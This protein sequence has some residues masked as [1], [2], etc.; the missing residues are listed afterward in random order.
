MPEECYQAR[1][2]QEVK[3]MVRAGII[4]SGFSAEL[5]SEGYRRCPLSELIAASSPTEEHIRRFA[6]REGLREFYTNYERMLERED[7]DLVS[8]CVPN[9]LHHQVVIS[10]LEAGKNV[11]CEKPLAVKIAQ[12]EEMVETAKKKGVRLFYAENWLFAPALV[13]VMEI[14]RSGAIGQVLYFKAKES[15]SGSHSPYALKKKYCGGGSLIHLGIHPVGF[16]LALKEGVKPLSVY[17]EVSGGGENNLLHPECEGEDFALLLIHFED[18]STGLIEANYITRGGLNNIVEIYGSE[19]TIKVDF[20]HGSPIKV[21]SI[22]GYDYAVEKAETTQGWSFP[23]F[24]EIWSQGLVQEI[25]HFVE[26]VAE[27]TDPKYGADGEG[28]KL[29]LQLVMAGYES[30]EKGEAVIL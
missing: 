27:D 26:C 18:D 23:A 24:D 20:S 7:I 6:E 11:I 5:H 15:H 29:A 2:D 3:S 13:R 22:K 21:F 28:G 16:G 10:A 19:G 14:V 12:A 17:A 25:A 30:A 8:V 1:K 4:G 9:Y